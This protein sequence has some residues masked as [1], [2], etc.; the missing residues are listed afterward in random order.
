MNHAT[1]RVPRNTKSVGC[2]RSLKRFALPVLAAGMM[3]SLSSFAQAE[4]DVDRGRDKANTCMGCHGAPGIR[5]AYPSFNVPKLA[6]QQSEYIVAA[7]IAY[8]DKLRDH[9]TMQAQ[10][11]SLSDE[12]IQDIAS[13]YTQFGN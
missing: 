7:L 6:G 12:D 13:Y 8:R 10:A 1:G 5:N 9:P 11:A 2:D 4:G 3:L